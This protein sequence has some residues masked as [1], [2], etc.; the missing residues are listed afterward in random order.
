MSWPYDRAE[1]VEPGTEVELLE[2]PRQLEEGYHQ[3]EELFQPQLDEQ[4]IV[5]LRKTDEQLWHAVNHDGDVLGGMSFDEAVARDPLRVEAL[6]HQ[7]IH[8]EFFEAMG[9]TGA[10]RRAMGAMGVD[11]APF[12]QLQAFIDR[13]Q[14]YRQL[15]GHLTAE[16]IADSL[17][18]NWEQFSALL[19]RMLLQAGANHPVGLAMLN[20]YVSN[21]D[22]LSRA[23]REAQ[24]IAHRAARVSEGLGRHDDIT[25]WRSVAAAIRDMA[26]FV[27]HSIHAPRV[28]TG[29]GIVPMGAAPRGRQARRQ[30]PVRRAPA[31]ERRQIAPP[32]PPAVT[33]PTAEAI[34]NWAGKTPARNASLVQS[35]DPDSGAIIWSYLGKKGTPEAIVAIDGRS[36]P[37][38]LMTATITWP[39]RDRGRPVPALVSCRLRWVLPRI[40]SGSW[41]NQLDSV[42]ICSVDF[43]E[44]LII[45]TFE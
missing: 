18:R 36:S 39:G 23:F 16:L 5:H 17:H 45:G 29:A 22:R 31:P 11:V 21:W 37:P 13:N 33:G 20:F 38:D 42:L 43:S 14:A 30:Q 41:P 25:A 6:V 8:N 10:Q 27:D 35:T 44:E 3:A 7:R 2:R 32:A 19:T 4:E 34:V 26:E 9:A 1:E 24:E 15:H 12:G 40:T 28:P